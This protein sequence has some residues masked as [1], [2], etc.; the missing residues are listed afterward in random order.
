MKLSKFL[1]VIFSV[2]FVSLLY[3]YQQT[4]II[5][6]A[7]A[8]QK[9][10][11]LFEELLDKNSALRYNLGKNVSL[12]KLG[13]KISQDKDFQMPETYR[14]VKLTYPQGIVTSRAVVSGRK[15]NLF[16]R[17]FGVKEQAEA[18]TINP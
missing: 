9:N 16:T 1:S 4:E 6:L 12:V 15:D 10:A 7:Y 14:L 8:G 2:T 13:S 18:R 3:V 11:V 5:R 17:I